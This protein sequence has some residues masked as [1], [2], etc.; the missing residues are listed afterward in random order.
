VY[1]LCHRS[2]KLRVMPQPPRYRARNAVYVLSAA[3]FLTVAVA[4]LLYALGYSFDVKSGAVGKNGLVVLSSTPSNAFITINDEVRAERTNA[5]LKLPPGNYKVK[6][7]RPGTQAWERRI[8]LGS[9]EAVL[10]DDILLFAA[11]PERTVIAETGVTARVL[12]ADS[13]QV[14]YI[15]RDAAGLGLW[16]AGSGER[17]EPGRRASLPEAFAAPTSLVF[18]DS[19]SVMAVSSPTE[20]L[21]ISASG[22]SSSQTVPLGG[23]V[24]FAPDSSERLLSLQGNQLVASRPGGGREL[25]ERGVSAWTTTRSAIY[26]VVDNRLYRREL[27]AARRE[28]L[29]AAGPDATPS[30]SPNPEA[31]PPLTEL[32]AR[33]GSESLFAKDAADALYTI[34][35]DRLLRVAK[36][37][38]GYQATPDGAF[39]AYT[40]SRQLNVWERS[41][42]QSTLVTRFSEPLEYLEPFAAGTYV[43]YGLKGEARA[44][45]AN[46][47][48]DHLLTKGYAA[49]PL[50]TGERRVVVLEPSGRLVSQGLLPR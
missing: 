27:S 40:S 3:I 37:V 50:L 21:V 20:T 46:G 41:S 39:V 32:T 5:R 1:Q 42:R 4:T 6:V 13:R 26:M 15:R 14:G 35:D 10:E 30:A 49:P 31:S 33:Q 8:H 25:L 44:V 22:S 7:D 48:N 18:N 24:R 43:L 9:G 38:E 34:A 23:A 36:G 19:G 12:S 17:T 11:Q 2:G 16:V 45:T 47:S 28:V 29:P